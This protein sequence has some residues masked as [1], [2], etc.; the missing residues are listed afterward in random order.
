MMLGRRGAAAL[1]ASALACCGGGGGTPPPSMIVIVWD[2][3][4]ADHL[5]LYGYDK[6]TTPFLSQL[7]AESLVFDD[8]RSVASSTVPSHG[9][10][11]T[12]LMPREHG[13]DNQTLMLD[14]HFDT[15]A[16]LLRGAGYATY[17]YSANPNL[18]RGAGFAQGF[19]VEEH[20]WDAQRRERAL[21]LLEE[22]TEG[23][24]A[25]GLAHILARGDV[26]HVHL[27]ACGALANDALLDFLARSDRER[28]F[29][30]FLNYME[31]HEPLVPPRAL[32]ERFLSPEEVE[33]SYTADR[34]WRALSEYNQGLRAFTAE[35]L[36]VLSGVY[37]AALLE[38]DQ[39]LRDLCARLDAA[40]RLAGT[41]IVVTSDHGEHLGEHGL[42]GH[43]YSLYEGLLRVPL[44]I[45]APG[46]LAPGRS[47]APV[48]NADLFTTLL[49][50]CGIEPP[51]RPRSLD[52]RA[53]PADR[54]RLAEYPG[55]FPAYVPPG[56]SVPF[57]AEDARWLRSFVALEQGGEKVISA[58]DGASELYRVDV[59]PGERRD[60]AAEDPDGLA[61]ALARLQAAVAGLQPFTPKAAER[62]AALRRSLE[63]VGY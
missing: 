27:K 42:T 59:D 18:V 43:R 25:S 7:A 28:P 3:V 57:T 50:L 62:D 9:S 2:T 58:S 17:L 32:R 48:T 8:C 11:F 22:K 45:R 38:L 35:D 60:L 5:S 1:A 23:D 34:S 53:V 51:A 61:R 26:D 20:P 31:A 36:A 6:E 29:F 13:A 16:E 55:D 56:V 54:A 30:A 15:L 40:G 37:D 46:R 19:D 10:L 14:E 63:D 4:R 41:L 24:R 33:R 49:V 47:A 39:L 52:V 21:A 12:G 44:V